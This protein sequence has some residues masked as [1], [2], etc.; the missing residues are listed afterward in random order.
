MEEKLRDAQIQIEK[1]KLRNKELKELLLLTGND[2]NAG[3]K[4]TVLEK[5]KGVKCLVLG[6]SIVR[7]VGADKSN[8]SV[9]FSGN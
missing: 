5:S 6:D 1:L 7:N 9:E 4:G 3:K 2:K 8:M